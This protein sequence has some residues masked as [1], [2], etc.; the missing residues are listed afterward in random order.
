MKIICNAKINWDSMEKIATNS[1]C[2]IYR[3]KKYCYKIYM[4]SMKFQNK[5]I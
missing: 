4:I 2:V 3:D 1:K 5:N